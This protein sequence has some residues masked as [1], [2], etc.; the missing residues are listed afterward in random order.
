[1]PEMTRRRPF[2]LVGAIGSLLQPPHTLAGDGLVEEV[3]IRLGSKVC[4]LFHTLGIL[5]ASIETCSDPE[6]M[7][8]FGGSMFV[9]GGIAAMMLLVLG[10]AVK[11]S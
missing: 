2:S 4:G 9:L 6:D 3:V 7:I 8:A 11:P 10:R 1:M 5:D